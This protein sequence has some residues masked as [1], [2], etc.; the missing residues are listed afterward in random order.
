VHGLPAACGAATVAA[1]GGE[2]GTH[3]EG[4]TTHTQQAKAP[5]R[6]TGVPAAPFTLHLLRRFEVRRRGEAVSLPMS[7]QRL[8]AFL[9]LNGRP[10]QRLH[11]AGKLWIDASE[12]HANASLRTALW[13]LKCLDAR[14]VAASSTELALADTVEVDVRETAARANAILRGGAN[15]AASL[16]ALSDAGELLPDWYDDWVLIERERLRQ[17]VLRAL[18]RLSAQ[19]RA[20]GRFADA[21]EAGLAAIAQEPLRESAHRLVVEAHLAD[22][23]RGEAIRHYRVYARLVRGE[24]GCGPSPLM[25]GLLAGLPVDR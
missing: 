4:A 20:A 22:G 7:T 15:G 21:V 6:T 23:N 1:R 2:P 3:P 24:L 11:V 9:A 13:R 14:V 18:E 16:H 19:A 8:V 17:L 25:R 5:A 12:E 10:L